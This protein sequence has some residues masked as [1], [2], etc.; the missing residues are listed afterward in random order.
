MRAKRYA[1]F[2]FKSNIESSRT[3]KVPDDDSFLKILGISFK[4]STFV[5]RCCGLALGS[6]SIQYILPNSLSNI[7]AALFSNLTH[8]LD[9]PEFEGPEMHNVKLV[10]IGTIFQ[11][12][13]YA[14][15]S[16]EDEILYIQL[17]SVSIYMC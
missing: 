15:G 16:Y 2:L 1:M 11:N 6:P 10:L 7:C 17:S 5:L 3:Y 14:G 12:T 4:N 9:F 13:M 8:R